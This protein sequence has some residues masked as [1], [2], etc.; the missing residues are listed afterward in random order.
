MS[1]RFFAISLMVII[2][3][4]LFPILWALLGFVLSE[5]TGCPAHEGYIN[6]CKI[7]GIEIG[8]FLYGS[9]TAP[10]LLFYT[11]PLGGVMLVVWVVAGLYS[12]FMHRRRQRKADDS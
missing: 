11:I 5:A 3:I 8:G 12:L 4:V 1:K 9:I 7:Y 6:P 2:G 10:W